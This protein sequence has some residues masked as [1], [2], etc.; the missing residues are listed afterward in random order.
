MITTLLE[1]VAAAM[2]SYGFSL[3]WAPLGWIVGGLLLGFVAYLAG[4]E[5]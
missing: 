3:A 1:L 4:G 5:A 2:V